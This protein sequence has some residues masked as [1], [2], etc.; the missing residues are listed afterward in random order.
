MAHL[1][2][3]GR[4]CHG[5]YSW[6]IYHDSLQW[7]TRTTLS[8]GLEK[9]ELP[10]FPVPFPSFC[11]PELWWTVSRFLIRKWHEKDVTDTTSRHCKEFPSAYMAG[12][13]LF[14]LLP[15]SNPKTPGAMAQ[16]EPIWFYVSILVSGK[17]RHWWDWHVC[18]PLSHQ[19]TRNAIQPCPLPKAVETLKPSSQPQGA[20]CY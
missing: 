18:L 4:K 12:T 9:K 17:L 16:W 2:G 11:S 19:Q 5:L 3:M 10:P 20:G 13:S 7:L 8:S 1:L 15:P 14:C 6:T